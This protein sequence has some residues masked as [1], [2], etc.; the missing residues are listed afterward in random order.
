MPAA[1]N[2]G[3]R[4]REGNCIKEG[5]SPREQGVNSLNQA[6]TK[7][8]QKERKTDTVSFKERS[9]RAAGFVELTSP[10]TL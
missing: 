2:R 8:K 5:F 6:V 3:V 9:Q 1:H 7:T 4:L 10:A